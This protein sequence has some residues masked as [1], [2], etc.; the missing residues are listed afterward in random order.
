MPD[1][2]HAK[3][4]REKHRHEAEEIGIDEPFIATLVDTFYAH[5]RADAV[6]G[7]IFAGRIANWPHHL[8]RMRSFWRSILLHTGEFSGNPMLKHMVIPDIGRDEF[9]RWLD[10]FA[11]TLAELERDPQASTRILAKA[12]AIAESLH[13]GIQIHRDGITDPAAMTGL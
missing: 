3:V 6:L 1:R 7:P 10:I 5:I 2:S 11:A 4:I 13:M 9:L 12:R 8:N